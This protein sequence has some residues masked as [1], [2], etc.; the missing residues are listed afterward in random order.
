MGRHWHI[1]VVDNNFDLVA[2]TYFAVAGFAVA[3]LAV[4]QVV[5][6]SGLT[7]LIVVLGVDTAQ[8][9]TVSIH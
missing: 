3:V 1:P 7:M 4:G 2:D 6:Q 9:C 8:S 5:R